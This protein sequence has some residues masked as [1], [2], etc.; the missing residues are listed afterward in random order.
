MRSFLIQNLSSGRNLLSDLY[1]LRCS[2]CFLYMGMASLAGLFQNVS[3][4]IVCT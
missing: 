2:Q 4:L 3:P 1:L